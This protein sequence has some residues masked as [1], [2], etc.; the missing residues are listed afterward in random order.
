MQLNTASTHIN[1][2]PKA[3]KSANGE[4]SDTKIPQNHMLVIHIKF[5]SNPLKFVEA[6]RSTIFFDT[7]LQTYQLTPCLLHI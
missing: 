7:D 2:C 4:R 6:D 5:H 1:A 3:H